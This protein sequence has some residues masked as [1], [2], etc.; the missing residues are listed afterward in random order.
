LKKNLSPEID[1]FS[2]ADTKKGTSIDIF[3]APNK[4]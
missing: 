4:S 3:S 2:S 1:I